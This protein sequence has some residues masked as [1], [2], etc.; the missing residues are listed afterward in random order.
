MINSSL[1]FYEYDNPAD[2]YRYWQQ[3]GKTALI[4]R[5]AS[6]LAGKGTVDRKSVV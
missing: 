1:G 6:M 3:D 5:T 2:S 4:S